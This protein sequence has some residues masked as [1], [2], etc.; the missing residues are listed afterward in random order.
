MGKQAFE[1]AETVSMPADAWEPTGPDSDPESRLLACLVIGGCRMHLEAYEVRID[2]HNTQVAANSLFDNNVSS[3]YCV[4][5][6]DKPFE[7]IDI[8]GKTYILV[9]TPYC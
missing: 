7:T 4:G 5:E 2:K 8:N 1:R 9:A 6:P 3:A